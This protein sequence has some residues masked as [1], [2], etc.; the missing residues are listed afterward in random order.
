MLIE[1][2]KKLGLKNISR[3]SSPI[4]V[5]IKDISLPYN[6]TVHHYDIYNLSGLV[7]RPGF[8]SSKETIKVQTVGEY[9]GETKGRFKYLLNIG[10]DIVKEAS[11]N[12]EDSNMEYIRY[13]K[14]NTILTRNNVLIKNYSMCNTINKY[15]ANPLNEYYGYINTLN[16]I[17]HHINVSDRNHFLPIDISIPTYG[18]LER[19]VDRKITV[20]LLNRMSTLNYIFFIELWKF[21]T[22]EFKEESAFNNITR[23][24]CKKLNIIFQ[25]G[26]NV[27]Y[28]NF[29]TLMSTIE[30]YQ[31]LDYQDGEHTVKYYN[32]DI[33]N[34]P[35]KR[36]KKLFYN[37]LKEIYT[38]RIT[39]KDTDETSSDRLLEEKEIKDVEDKIESTEKDVEEEKEFFSNE[40]LTKAD[41]EEGDDE[42][43]TIEVNSKGDLKELKDSP[44]DRIENKIE[45]LRNSK[46]YT[47]SKA[48]RL[49]QALKDQENLEFVINGK[50]VTYKDLTKPL[51]VNLDQSIV[52]I[53]PSKIGGDKTYYEDTIN[54]FDKSTIKSLP[55]II[56][57]NIMAVNKAG[58]IVKNMEVIEDSTILGD[59]QVLKFTL[60]NLDGGSETV[61]IV[62]SG[63]DDNG[64]FKISGNKYILR[65]QKA[66]APIRKISA[67]EVR[68]S[69]AFGSVS[70]TKAPS[71]RFEISFWVKNILNRMYDEKTISNLVLVVGKNKLHDI[72]LPKVYTY[73]NK[74]VKM[75]NKDDYHFTF[76]YKYR[77]S[78]LEN[79]YSDKNEVKKKLKEIEEYGVFIGIKGKTPLVLTSDDRVLLY[80]KNG[81]KEIEGL[82]S[83]LGIDLKDS[84]VASST[85]QVIN[86]KVPVVVAL[87]FYIGLDNILKA[88]NAKHQFI[89]LDSTEELTLE[90]DYFKV[91]FLDGKLYIERDYGEIDMMLGGLLAIKNITSEINF[92]S[93]ST[94]KGYSGVFNLMELPLTHINTITLMEQMFVDDLTLERLILI[95]EPT[96]FIGLLIRSIELLVDDYY[97][98]PKDVHGEIFKSYDRVGDFVYKELIDSIRAAKN[99]SEFGKSKLSVNP[100]NVLQKINQDPTSVIIDDT[101]PLG[102]LRQKENVTYLGAG[103]RSKESMSKD[104][105]HIHRSEI[106]IM[107][108]SSVDSGNVGINAYM[109]AAPRLSNSLGS[110]GEI[111]LDND[112]WASILTSSAMMAPYITSDDGKRVMFSNAQNVHIIPTANMQLPYVVTPYLSLI[113]NKVGGDYAGVSEGEGVVKN[114]TKKEVTVEY[115]TKPLH[116]EKVTSL[117]YKELPTKLLKS[118]YKD[119]KASD[120]KKWSKDSFL[121]VVDGLKINGI[122]RYTKNKDTNLLSLKGDEESKRMLIERVISDS[123]D[124]VITTNMEE[125]LSAFGFTKS[126]GNQT[127]KVPKGTNNKTYTKKY[128]LKTWFSKEE[129]NSTFEHVLVSNVTKGQ[130]VSKDDIITYDKSFFI[131]NPYDT[132]RVFYLQGRTVRT[133]FL[134]GIEEHEDSGAISQELVKEMTTNPVKVKDAIITKE[135][136]IKELIEIGSNVTHETALFKK[137]DKND[138]LLAD[139][140]D[141]TIKDIIAGIK[142]KNL[143]ASIKGKVIDIVIYYNTEL[144]ELDESLKRYI[145]ESDERLKDKTG[146]TGKVN[147]SFS[148]RGKSLREGEI[149]IKVY[150]KIE[151]D[152]GI[153][154]KAILG[155][156]LKFTVGGMLDK[157]KGEDGKPI[158]L[159]F[160]VIG[161]SNR[162]VLSV[163]RMGLMSSYCRLRTERIVSEYF[164]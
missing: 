116:Y 135:Q 39:N 30:E 51:E 16:T 129:D 55:V 50:K 14:K 139:V 114:I 109:S 104:T 163:I 80:S 57:K 63:T 141:N 150:V 28:V 162:I 12:N 65:K 130:K 66:D 88:Y 144:E 69:S 142:N 143:N 49:K 131:P 152:L 58:Y 154:D 31:D 159:S 120:F 110:T 10:K 111:D 149:Y 151:D 67:D 106:G 94:K 137:S 157:V 37:Y 98:D 123:N 125:D 103:G 60:E 76:N 36:L 85:I 115:S 62:L 100:Y 136:T 124:T 145:E 138:G 29:F 38:S 92:K 41:I 48:A 13:G 102:I 42:P 52:K 24:G 56:G 81:I 6:S 133:A 72:K 107:G 27:S 20:S 75:F 53:N 21:L 3:L 59:Q 19:L 54:A 99:R 44:T 74:Y 90:G 32:E 134:E 87:G 64:I 7:P 15:E 132:T 79:I 17:F 84:P 11:K 18:I 2:L 95:K 101:N 78:L 73:F 4:I 161:N 1:E 71:K 77:V 146:Y 61:K 86:K 45:N 23:E 122:L 8:V 148:V 22:P 93:L 68:L 140:E 40:E 43:F 158:D 155:H 82:F 97:L 156:Q 96:T 147:S 9:S 121:T 46:I 91:P 47:S 117:T 34:L 112:G 33:Q 105:R 119:A 153:G 160:S 89:K 127:L 5:N 26:D 128:K 164:S 83:I 118:F 126:K 108:E 113:A 25:A 35:S 70:I